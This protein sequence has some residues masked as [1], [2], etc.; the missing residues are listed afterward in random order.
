MQTHAEAVLQ[1]LREVAHTIL[2]TCAG[3]APSSC[4]VKSSVLQKCPT[5]DFSGL[6]VAPSL[7]HP[8][9]LRQQLSSR[10]G[11]AKSWRSQRRGSGASSVASGQTRTPHSP[12][13]RRAE[14]L[15]RQNQGQQLG[16]VMRFA[17]S[18]KDCSEVGCSCCGSNSCLDSHTCKESPIF[19][20]LA[21]TT[22]A[23]FS[24]HESSDAIKPQDSSL[25]IT[26]NDKTRQL[27]YNSA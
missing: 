16:S 2:A 25:H 24:Q 5:D 6:S 19:A 17:E 23:E 10:A 18:A 22:T 9:L 12:M 11:T 1:E 15:R 8:W 27:V 20:Q 4:L 21:A 3:L 26:A 14:G 7:K 13:I